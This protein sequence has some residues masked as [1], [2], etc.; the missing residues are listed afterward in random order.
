MT[1]LALAQ[2]V[3]EPARRLQFP[4]QIREFSFLSRL[5]MDLYKPAGSGP[6]PALVLVHSCSGLRLGLR[7]R[8]DEI[9]D[10]AER[11]IKR[12]YAVLVI[13]HF[14]QRGIDSVCYPPL[15]LRFT[16]AVRDVHDAQAHLAKFP[17]IDGKRVGL[18]GFSW[19]AMLGLLSA[20]PEFVAR[21]GSPPGRFAALASFYPR[22]YRPAIPDAPIQGWRNDFAWLRDDTDRPLLALMGGLDNETPPEH[23]LPRLEATKQR[24]G[25][26]E[27]HL[28]PSATHCWDCTS[29]DGQIKTDAFGARVHYKYDRAITQDSA[30]R[31]FAFLDRHLKTV[32]K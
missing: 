32:A 1:S 13:D 14:T 16:D 10:W 25:P 29:L 27:W 24:G 12:G 31:L 20:S 6:F 30:D 15:R 5:Q 7:S 8:A 26:V 21:S 23:C 17:E 22:C 2:N 18:V 19:G 9:L 11:A 28:Y 4:E 3:A